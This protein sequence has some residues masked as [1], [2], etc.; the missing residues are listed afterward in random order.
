[1]ERA[2]VF[3]R[4]KN[5]AKGRKNDLICSVFTDQFR[6]NGMTSYRGMKFGQTLKNNRNVF[7]SEISRL[8]ENRNFFENSTALQL[9]RNIFIDIIILYHIALFFLFS[10][11]I[12][13]HILAII[14]EFIILIYRFKIIR[15]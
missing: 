13:I 15:K 6:R 2:L 14:S 8:E 9:F 10:D 12:I 4:N 11:F 5:F 7:L 3:T 1:M